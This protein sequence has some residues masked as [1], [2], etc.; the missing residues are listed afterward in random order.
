LD[1]ECD[2]YCV[3]RSNPDLTNVNTSSRLFN[4]FLVFSILEI[5]CILLNVNLNTEPI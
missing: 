5:N 2:L 4:T 1:I 3:P